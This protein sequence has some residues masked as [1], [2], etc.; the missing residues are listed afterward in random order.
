MNAMKIKIKNLLFFI[1][2]NVLIFLI[3]E[4][5]LTFFFI[6][7]Q[8]NYFGPIAKI[9]YKPEIKKKEIDIYKIRWNRHTQKMIPGT[10]RHND[11]EFKVNSLGF[12]GEE[13]SIK[14]E[15]GCRLIS[16]GGSTTAGLGNYYPYPKILEE[17]LHNNNFDCEVLNFGFS[18]KSLNFIEN[19]LVNEAVNY[20]PNIITIQSNR[21]AVMYDSY[22]NSSIS[23]D[24]ISS[25]FDYYYYKLKMFLFS[26]IMT[27]RFIELA[28]K[29][30]ISILYDDE[31]KIVS[32]Y[33]ANTYHLKNYFT[34]KYIN[35]MNNIINFCKN[36]D[37]K[38]VLIKQ[39]R[40]IDLEYQ[41]ILRGLSKEKILNKL[42]TYQKEK[43]RNKIDLFWM[44]TSAI[45]NKSL[46]EIKLNNPDIILVDPIEEILK[47]KKEI[48]FVDND[49][50]HLTRHGNKIVAEKIMLAIFDSVKLLASP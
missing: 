46:D 23:P 49:D 4:L 2:A 42:L 30:I 41:K 45:I 25:K 27:Y 19:L 24:V 32:P 28:S 3:L 16:F 43:K 48:N 7:H 22:G 33:R 39:P 20:S 11:V 38:V 5:F 15:K 47:Y 26:K 12:L 17:K 37:I 1:F 9:F 44:Y 34:S 6:Y 18:G 35:Q 13:F 8:S 50:V 21:N 40:Y 36:N 10:Y 14:N 31:N 29:R